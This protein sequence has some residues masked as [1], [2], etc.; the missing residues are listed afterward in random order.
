[1]K[2]HKTNSHRAWYYKPMRTN[3]QLCVRF[4]EY[5]MALIAHL[6]T[7]TGHRSRSDFV[8]RQLFTWLCRSYRAEIDEFNR[9]CNLNLNHINGID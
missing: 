7:E 6:A 3:E 1:M 2:I 4:T 8:R 9:N 5:E